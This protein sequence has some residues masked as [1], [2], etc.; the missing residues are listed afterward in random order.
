MKPFN[1]SVLGCLAVLVPE[2][3]LMPAE[4]DLWPDEGWLLWETAEAVHRSAMTKVMVFL[5]STPR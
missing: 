4:A 5:K 3:L 1:S 2:R